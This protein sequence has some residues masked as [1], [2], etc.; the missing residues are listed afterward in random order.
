[1]KNCIVYDAR[2][3]SCTGIGT[4]IK[5][6]L[7]YLVKNTN[8][9]FYILHKSIDVIGIK[10]LL[11][12]QDNVNFIVCNIKEYSLKEQ[13]FLPFILKKVNPKISHFPNINIPLLYFGNILTTVHDL[14]MLSHSFKNS[15]ISN[16]FIFK[17]KNYFLN[18]CFK[19]AVNQKNIIVVS[20]QTKKDLKNKF[21][22]KAKITL[23][24]N[25]LKADYYNDSIL[26]NPT[27]YLK[28]NCLKIEHFEGRQIYR[29]TGL[30][31]KLE[32]TKKQTFKDNF[33]N[34]VLH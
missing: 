18:K 5:S 3:F 11:K 15:N 16:P 10:K 25:T 2:L 32:R 17:V 29:I 23:S 8:A 12:N 33:R 24:Y 30:T 26:K 14:T 34:V 31:T 7:P 27:S 28:E 20:K 6:S 13:L 1:M 22:V 21:K 19:K 9:L 4:H